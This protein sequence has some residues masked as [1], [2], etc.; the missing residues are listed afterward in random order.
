MKRN[1]VSDFRF[2]LCFQPPRSRRRLSALSQCYE[3]ELRRTHQQNR[4]RRHQYRRYRYQSF[5]RG[6]QLPQRFADARRSVAIELTQ[7]DV[8]DPILG[9][10]IDA[11]RQ[12][13]E[14]LPWIVS[15]GVE[16]RFPDQLVVQVTEAE[17]MALWQRNQ[18][19]FL[20]SRGGDASCRKSYPARA[21][22]HRRREQALRRLRARAAASARDR[23]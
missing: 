13:L 5:G 2:H 8:A 3:F 17:P 22:L 12:R 21:R 18:K 23:L 14:D 15:A 7:A 11:V 20:V 10:D 1:R 9:I 19:L 6:L 16:R 4:P